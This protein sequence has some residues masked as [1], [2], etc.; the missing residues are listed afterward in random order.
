MDFGPEMADSAERFLQMANSHLRMNERWIYL[1][2]QKSLWKKSQTIGLVW[3]IRSFCLSCALQLIPQFLQTGQFQVS[4][5]QHGRDV[6]G[7]TCNVDRVGRH[8]A[9]ILL[10]LLS[11]ASP[12]HAGVDK[13][14]Q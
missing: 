7:K 1:W 11:V 9:Q 8:E 5:Q 6:L 12:N 3:P 2:Y 10:K 13:T 14:T 4:R